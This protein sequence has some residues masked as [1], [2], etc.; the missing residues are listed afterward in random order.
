[1]YTKIIRTFPNS[2]TVGRENYHFNGVARYVM[3]CLG[4]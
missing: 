4:K 2:K 3:S 1:M